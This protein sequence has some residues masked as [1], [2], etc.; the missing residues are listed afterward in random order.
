MVMHTIKFIV[1]TPEPFIYA[2]IYIAVVF[3][4][5]YFNKEIK[6]LYNSNTFYKNFIKYTTYVHNT[7][8]CI[9]SFLTCFYISS[10]LYSLNGSINSVRLW[11]DL[12]LDDD[13]L[14]DICWYFTYS[15]VWEFL[16]T[17]LIMLKGNDTIFLQKY[18]HAGAVIVF[19]LAS[20]AKIPLIVFNAQF[21]SFV[22]T[23]MYSYY[24]ITSTGKKLN[25]IKPLITLLQ[26]VQ[27]IS[28]ISLACKNYV[29]RFFT[30]YDSIPV[31]ITIIFITYVIILIMLFLQFF[32][33]SYCLKRKHN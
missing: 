19:Y 8:L 18:H 13:Y 32:I 15:K 10:Y 29:L 4:L 21:N 9:F 2:G 12:T 28:G 26:L 33:K 22:H 17:F 25:R 1:A 16:D 23:I 27:L 20:K 7:G 30:T 24:L 14:N 3:L 5:K 11:G 6:T 31:N